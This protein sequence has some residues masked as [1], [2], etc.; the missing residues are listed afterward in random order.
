VASPIWSAGLDAHRDAVGE[1][2]AGGSDM[3]KILVDFGGSMTHCEQVQKLGDR[4]AVVRW[5]QPQV[6]DVTG[7]VE[8]F[9]DTHQETGEQIWTWNG[10]YEMVAS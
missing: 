5:H 6:G 9:G 3:E 1:N 10:D 4:T 8:A 2:E 7:A